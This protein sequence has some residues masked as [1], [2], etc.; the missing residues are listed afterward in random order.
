MFSSSILDLTRAIQL[1]PYGNRHQTC[2]P[3]SWNNYIEGWDTAIHEHSILPEEQVRLGDGTT[4]QV[5]KLW[6]SGL[7]FE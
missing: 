2:S 3:Y 4:I 6:T 5:A 7:S 1:R